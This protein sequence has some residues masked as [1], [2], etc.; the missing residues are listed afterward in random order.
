[1]DPAVS[2]IHNS[3]EISMAKRTNGVAEFSRVGSALQWVFPKLGALQIDATE[4]YPEWAAMDEVQQNIILNGLKQKCA[5]GMASAINEQ[6]RYDRMASIMANLRG[7]I[8][9]A[10][11]TGTASDAAIL[12]QAIAE[13]DRKP[14][15]K[16]RAYVDGL[17]K[18]ARDALMSHALYKGVCDEIK[19]QRAT[20]VDVDDLIGEIGNL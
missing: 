4:F 15:T 2:I 7:G 12:A 6:D 5:D 14:L 10:R 9:S 11:G 17:T 3:M 1:M 18:S 13:V 16:C 19:A 20:A 8:W